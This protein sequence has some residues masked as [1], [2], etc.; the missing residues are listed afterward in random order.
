MS[1]DRGF[2]LR[3][4]AFWPVLPA[5]AAANGVLRETLL[6]PALG[7]RAALPLSGVL[8]VALVLGASAVF[9]ALVRAPRT[10]GE[11]WRLGAL[12][13]GLA[14][15]F[16]VGVFGLIG[17]A[18]MRELLAALDPATGNLFALALLATLAGPRLMAAA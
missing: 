5:L 7:A 17:G 1:V 6:A 2:L 14:L 11:L 18:P 15:A 4:L 12:W 16:E 10:P 3:G 13:A 8:F 9:L